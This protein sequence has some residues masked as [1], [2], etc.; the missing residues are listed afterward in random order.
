MK[1]ALQYVNDSNG[2]TKAVQLSLTDWEKVLA[3]LRKYEQTL[4]IKSDLT[5]A[6]EEVALLKKSKEKQQSLTEFLTEL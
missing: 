2:K 6:F 4:R 5:E 1:L 3:K